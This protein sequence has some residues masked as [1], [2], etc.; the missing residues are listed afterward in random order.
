[1]TRIKFI[2][3]ALSL[4]TCCR[5]FAS[6]N[7]SADTLKEKPEGNFLIFPFFLKSPETNWGFGGASAYFFRPDKKVEDIRT[8]DFNLVAL[9]TLRNQ[10]VIVLG[11]TVYFSK[12][13]TILRYE[14]SYSYYPD[15]C[16]GI[17]NQSLPSA[18]EKYSIKQFYFNP[19]FLRKF[20]RH[21]YAGFTYEIQHIGKFIYQP[22]GVFDKE[23]IIGRFG[24]NT[25]G[26]GFLL[27]WDTR[28]NAYSSSKGFFIEMSSKVF[29]KKI[30][31]DFNF[32]KLALDFRNF[33]S[34][35]GKQVLAMQLIINEN[36]GDIP[37][38]HLGMLGGSEIMRGYYKGRYMDNDLI[39]LQAELRQHLF[40]RIGI[41]GFAST[42]EV[43]SHTSYFKLDALHYAYGGGLRLMVSKTEKLNL[44]IDFGVGKNSTGLYVILKEAF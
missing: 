15:R 43:A 32:Y 17:G 18:E 22:N 13:K 5:C 7:S 12:E 30:G 26:I 25:S 41:T 23:H 14:S 6:G 38:R 31:S 3:F 36:S 16:W 24:G 37:I 34:L 39:A 42:G 19:Q 35:P 20:F 29:D 1:M 9:Y 21:W 11:S 33:I 2:A 28:N 40:G 4:L 8:S 10:L 27:T 44:R